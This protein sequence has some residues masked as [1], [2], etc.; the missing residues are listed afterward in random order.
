MTLK[1][2]LFTIIIGLL[3]VISAL[4]STSESRLPISNA[5]EQ[6]EHCVVYAEATA[7]GSSAA[8]VIWRGC[9]PTFAE[10]IAVATDGGQLPPSSSE[11]NPTDAQS[12]FP[13][14]SS[15]APP[16]SESNSDADE[17]QSLPDGISAQGEHCVVYAE[18]TAPGS[19]AAPVIW[20]CQ[21]CLAR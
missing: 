17:S 9:Y 8:P 1:P 21:N 16:V 15:V 5:Q 11:D 3:L 6:G 4:V 2:T 12:A 10:A 13:A 7:P 18:A 20:L 14:A 19:S